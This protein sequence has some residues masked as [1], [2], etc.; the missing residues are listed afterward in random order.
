[1]VVFSDYG[2]GVLSKIE[3]LI[4]IAKKKNKTILV[5]PKGTDYSRYSGSDIIT[6]NKSELKKV[7]G[8][9]CSEE[10]LFIKVHNLR[11]KIGVK[12]ILL[13]RSEEGM[14]YFFETDGIDKKFDIA[15]NPVEVFDVS[16]AG[17]T[18]IST[19]AILLACGLPIE[20]CLTFSN[21]A[22]GIVVSKLG[23]ANLTFKELFI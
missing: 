3:D 16:G 14:T 10:D 23:T 11:K 6:P 1:V 5:D 17:D 22:G 7:I 21:K 2:K 13:T 20:E 12:S 19:L 4:I 9:W 15:S 8:E 18:V